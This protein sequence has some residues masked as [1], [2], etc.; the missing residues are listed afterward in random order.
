MPSSTRKQPARSAK[1]NASQPPMRLVAQEV[2]ACNEY[3]IRFRSGHSHAVL[4]PFWDGPACP[5]R[6]YSSTRVTCSKLAGQPAQQ[7]RILWGL[8]AVVPQPARRLKQWVGQDKSRDTGAPTAAALVTEAS[9]ST[10]QFYM[11]PKCSKVLCRV[12]IKTML[13]C[14][15]FYLL[16]FAAATFN[17]R[18]HFL[19][20]Y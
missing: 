19:V 7:P 12:L 6:R 2:T 20:L 15:H 14:L 16:C 17:F 18:C 1:A 11:S 13:P 10:S 8:T 5:V 3:R 9:R 4:V